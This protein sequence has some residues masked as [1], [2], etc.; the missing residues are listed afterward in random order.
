MIVRVDSG[1]SVDL[2]INI[3]N[4]AIGMTERMKMALDK[5]C[6]Y[7]QSGNGEVANTSKIVGRLSEDGVY[8]QNDFGV[9]RKTLTI[10][11]NEINISPNPGYANIIICL[12]VCGST[13]SHLPTIAPTI[14]PIIAPTTSKLPSAAPVAIPGIELLG[15]FVDKSNR[16]SHVYKGNHKSLE[17]CRVLCSVYNYF[18]CQWSNECRCGDDSY[19][20]YGPNPQCHC[21][22]SSN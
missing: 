18:G 8:T 4:H 15:C 5:V 9:T 22:S 12:G 21:S 3:S 10:T 11:V 14:N 20:K 1:G 2:Y 17:Q 19:D 7:E 13:I 16:A 6:V